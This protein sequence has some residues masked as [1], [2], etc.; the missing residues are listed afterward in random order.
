MN[1]RLSR[2][3]CSR[4]AARTLVSGLLGLFIAVP[5]AMAFGEQDNEAHDRDEHVNREERKTAFSIEDFEKHGVGLATARRGVVGAG[6]E[7]PAEVRPNA[8]RLAHVAARFPGI[9]REVRKHIGDTVRAGDVLALIE[10]ENLST[11]ELKAAF[12]GTIIDKHISPGEAA[13]RERPAFVIADLSSVWVNINVYQ[14]V[15]PQ[16]RLGQSVLISTTD[17]VQQAEGTISYLAPVVH[18]ATRTATARVVLANADGVWRPGLFVVATIVV[19]TEAD[20]VVPRRALHTLDG[21]TVL[22]V[23][24][25]DSFV[26]RP[27]TV[28]TIGDTQ[29]EITSGLRAGERFADEGSFLVKAELAKDAGGHHH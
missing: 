2:H 17:D 11:Y 12:D 19:P 29:A 21:K 23:A 16:V 6:V 1:T 7:L 20:I 9:V 5:L 14:K 22:F 4:P 8:D 10:S 15:L 24:E 18:Q 26:A 27:V 25:E 28:G 13:S 3:H